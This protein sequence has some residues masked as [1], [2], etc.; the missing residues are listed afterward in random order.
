MPVAGESA[1]VD[2]ADQE[3][4]SSSGNSNEVSRPTKK[5]CQNMPEPTMTGEN[6]PVHLETR[7]GEDT[8]A[9]LSYLQWLRTRQ[10]EWHNMQAVL[11]EEFRMAAVSATMQI[12]ML[13][14]ALNLVRGATSQ[15]GLSERMTTNGCFRQKPQCELTAWWGKSSNTA[16]SLADAVQLEEEKQENDDNMPD[17]RCR[18]WSLRLP[19]E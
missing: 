1:E 5:S 14:Q 16:M 18:G 13:L 2:D 11:V 10:L 8:R 4:S 9:L 3:E 7:R 15:K 17:E 19:D 12:M 6:D